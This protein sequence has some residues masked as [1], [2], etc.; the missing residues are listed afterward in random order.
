[1]LEDFSGHT[2]VASCPQSAVCLQTAVVPASL[3]QGLMNAEYWPTQLVHKQLK[4]TNSRHPSTPWMHTY[5]INKEETL[6]CMFYSPTPCGTPRYLEQSISGL[7]FQKPYQNWMQG[8][9]WEPF[10]TLLLWC[11]SNDITIICLFLL[12]GNPDACAVESCW[13]TCASAGIPDLPHAFP[14]RLLN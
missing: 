12:V 3:I 9:V 6:P 5:E 10:Y 8:P 7:P 1:M 11:H 2:E 13:L 14:H 4:K